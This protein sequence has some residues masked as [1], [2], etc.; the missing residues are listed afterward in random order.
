MFH[1]PL[2]A[3]TVFNPEICTYAKG[4]VAVDS[5]GKTVFTEGQGTDEIAV[6]VDSVKFFDHYFGVVH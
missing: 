2:A 5:N 1:D 4:N 6:A 3:V